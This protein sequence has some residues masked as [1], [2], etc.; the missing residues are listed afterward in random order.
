[1]QRGYIRVEAD[2]LTYPLH[3]IL[4]YEIEKALIGGEMEIGDIPDAWDEKMQGY[5]GLSTTGN[6]TDG[7]MQ[8]VHWFAGL[9]GYFP[10]YTLGALT[11]AQLFAAARDA[12]GDLDASLGRG[13]F[14]TLL[15]WL[16]SKVHGRGSF[17][18]TGEIVRDATGGPLGT[19][20]FFDHVAR[21]YG[22]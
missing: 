19:D 18:S 14:S 9:F 10:T 11:A 13:D 21:R 8:D 6:F 16:R 7:P 2:E 20:A 4:R 15:A 22:R 12:I 1:V 17:A 3:I 5:F